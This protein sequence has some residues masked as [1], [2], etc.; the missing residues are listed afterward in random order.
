L[1]IILIPLIV[2]G[3]SKSIPTKNTKKSRKSGI[4][5]GAYK[6]FFYYL[7]KEKNETYSFG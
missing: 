5:L 4:V 1:F 6:M 2:K 7:K 3:F